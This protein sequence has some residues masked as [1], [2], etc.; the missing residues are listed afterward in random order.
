MKEIEKITEKIITNFPLMVHK[1]TGLLYF[2]EFYSDEATN[3][4]R[5]ILAEK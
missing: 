4:F 5:F 3:Y 1:V 2:V